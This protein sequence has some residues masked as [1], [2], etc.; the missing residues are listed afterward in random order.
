MLDML[1]YNLRILVVYLSAYH[2][3][4]EDAFWSIQHTLVAY[5]KNVN[6][7][8]IFGTVYIGV[9]ILD[10]IWIFRFPNILIL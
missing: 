7:V 6:Y 2:T 8:Y 4:L 9:S 3:F 1:D 5:Y 10:W